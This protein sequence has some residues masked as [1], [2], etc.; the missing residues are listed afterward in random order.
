MLAGAYSGLAVR[1]PEHVDA[2]RGMGMTEWQ[3]FTK[4]ELPL[5][6][7]LVIGGLR[8]AALQVIAT[9]TVA[10]ILPVG[11]LGRYLFDGLAVQHYPEM[12]GGSILVVALALVIGRTLRRSPRSSSSPGA[13]SRAA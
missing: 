4:V 8:S 6:L 3:I 10:A 13:S 11:G 2:A 5:S 12:L 9:W 7:P 1:R